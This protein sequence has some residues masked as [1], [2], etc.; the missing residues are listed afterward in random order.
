MQRNGDGPIDRRQINEKKSIRPEDQLHFVCLVCM[1]V[2]CWIVFIHDYSRLFTIIH[3]RLADSFTIS[4][5]TEQRC[6]LSSY[7]TRSIY[8]FTCF[9]S[10]SRARFAS[11]ESLKCGQEMLLDVW[12]IL[13]KNYQFFQCLSL[14][15]LSKHCCV[16]YILPDI[17]TYPTKSIFLA[18]LC[19][20]DQAIHFSPS[21]L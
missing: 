9:S 1:Y 17:E 14:L 6:I 21:S 7:V 8:V 20:I 3:S 13:P 11:F 12:L 2:V 10:S 16:L 5:L 18:P 19:M 4:W 15:L